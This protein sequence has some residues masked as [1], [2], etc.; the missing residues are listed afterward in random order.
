M[1]SLL[2]ASYYHFLRAFMNKP[3]GIGVKIGYAL[4]VISIPLAFTGHLVEDAYISNSLLYLDLH[5]A[6]YG[7]ATAGLVLLGSAVFSLARQ[8]RLLKDALARS[9][10][11]YI[12][13]GFAVGIAFF[14]TNFTP[15]LSRYPLANLGN[16]INA[17][18]ITYAIQRY[19][20]LD[21]RL[22][23]R[24]GLTYGILT[25]VVIAIY[26]GM[27][28]IIGMYARVLPVYTV[29][30][31]TAIT[32]FLVAVFFRPVTK[33]TQELIDRRFF[34]QTYD[35]RQFLLS[36]S[37]KMS[38]VLN[39]EELAEN[40]LDPIIKALHT[41]EASLLLPDTETGDF[42]TKFAYRAD[43]DKSV[44]EP[45]LRKDNPILTW[46]A[47]EG[48][49]LNVDSIN[50]IP[51][52]KGLWKDERQ[53]LITSESELLLPIRSRGR[54]V[55]VLALTGKKSDNPYYT[56]DVSLL[57]TMANEAGIVIDNALIYSDAILRSHT[58]G[59]TGLFNHR[60]FHERL[61]EEISR[62]SRFGTTLSMIMMDLDLFK[63]YNDIYGHVAGDEV[64]RQIGQCIK[65]S[66]RGIDIACRYGGEEFTIILPETRLD[67]A[68]TVA[69]RIRKAIE[70]EMFTKQ[71]PLTAS[72]GVASWP[73]DGVTKE[74]LVASADGAM[75]LAKAMGRNRTCLSTEVVPTETPSKIEGKA[76]QEILGMVYA[77]AAAVDAKDHYTYGHSKK[78]A[79]SA[80]ALAEA[81]DLPPQKIATI[82]A[83]AMLHDI[84]KIGIPDETLTKPDR[85]T[86]DE[87]VLLRTHPQMGAQI[88]R[89]V[90]DLAN[91]VPGIQ[92]HHE[93]WDGT[94][95]PSGLKGENIPLDA[96]ILAIADAY[97]AMT[98]IRPYRKAMSPSEAIEELRRSAGTQLDPK[99]TELFV[100][101]TEASLSQK[102]EMQQNR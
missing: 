43:G 73:T 58:D 60:Y 78:V 61:E 98:S 35:Y 70:L 88:I 97:A 34:G 24:R 32:G 31:A 90:P 86:N 51:E 101:I 4:V 77:L 5:P 49:P 28:N 79:Q 67:D 42:T 84:G 47:K 89:H 54:L 56:E 83:T 20:L 13:I 80:I 17:F 10:I 36:Y 55:G 37:D 26:I 74:E 41:R 96:R 48:K 100:T 15:P 27:A 8:H 94:G 33:K 68:H 21:I 93:R 9:R 30:M 82:R 23:S 22:V 57:I 39:I 66:V 1:V 12:L 87:W 64:L 38:N 85:L 81:L 19:Q 53:Q 50:T 25:I 62:S 46:L 99:L 95:Y 59:L 29:I 11:A 63:P 72:L 102:L 76:T 14:I 3:A 69:E 65:H 44:A 71:I 6:I 45:Y 52:L 91:C 2:A 18:I 75:Y 92:H 40:M 7:L 16:I